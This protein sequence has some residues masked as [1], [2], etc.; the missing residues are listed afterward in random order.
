[1]P[2]VFDILT[3]DHEEVKAMLAELERG[4]TA[5]GGAGPDQL[6]LRKK[7]AQQLVIEESKHEAVEEEYFWP[8]VR[9][10][11]AA[12]D[13]LTDEATRQEQ[14][15]K[16]VLDRIG[17][18]DAGDSEFEELISSFIMAGRAH[19]A[20]EETRVWPAMRAVLQHHE[21]RELGEKLENGK[22]MAPTRPHPDTPPAPGILGSA[23]PAVAAADR[24]RDV[25]TGRGKS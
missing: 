25:M 6:A 5:A 1:M 12:G 7:M 11:L 23:G 19:I 24:F 15:A 18:L 13:R 4:P 20:F 2:N 14:D 21:V 10:K 9:E 16:A 22:G 3:K 8:A 17:K